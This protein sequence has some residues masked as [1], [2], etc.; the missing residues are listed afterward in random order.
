MRV[1]AAAVLAAS[2]LVTS[3]SSEQEQP[4]PQSTEQPP[5]TTK[6]A[7]QLV[8]PPRQFEPKGERVGTTPFTLTGDAVASVDTGE[9][10]KIRVFGLDGEPRKEFPIEVPQKA[11]VSAPY[12]LE[13]GSLVL[14]AVA[15]TVKGTGTS[16]DHMRYTVIAYNPKTGAKAWESPIDASD[17][18]LLPDNTPRIVGADRNTVV[19]EADLLKVSA[20]VALSTVDGTPKW[21]KPGFTAIGLAGDIVVGHHVTKGITTEAVGLAAGDGAQRWTGPKFD[22]EPR[23]PF[24]RTRMVGDRLASFAGTP[25]GE[26][27]KTTTYLLDTA[28]GQPRLTLDG[29]WSCDSDDENAVVCGRSFYGQYM[30]GFDATSMSKRWELPDKAAKREAPTLNTAHK[31]V[32]Y[33]TSSHGLMTLDARTGKDLDPTLGEL[34]DLDYVVPGYGISVVRDT[35]WAHRAVR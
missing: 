5:V 13:D 9:R 17:A 1:R 23:H 33:V 22:G 2:L 27:A 35:V 29:P 30:A 32:A 4:S 24:S 11:K 28:T 31:G 19:V 21:N 16:Q 3:C 26:L 14:L 10:P 12:G 15:H 8:N 18:L 7:T 6:P 20:T 34:D 25:A